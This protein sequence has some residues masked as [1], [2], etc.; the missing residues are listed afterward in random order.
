MY[1]DPV[2]KIVDHEERRAAIARAFQQHAAEHGFAATSYAKVA[3][4][5]GIS[6]GQI[7]HYFGDRHELLE[8]AYDDLVRRRDARVDAC[9]SRGEAAHHSIRRILDDALRELLPLD[10]DRS[11]EHR[12][13]QQLRL[14]AAHDPALAAL[15]QRAHRALHVRV[16]TAVGN[17]TSCG[18]VAAGVDA[19]VAATRILSVAYGLADVLALSPRPRRSRQVHEVLEPVVATVF[20]GRC[21]HH[22]D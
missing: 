14:E 4:A 7:Q 13:G 10:D 9:V 18:E 8:F 15:A 5:A 12:V 19:G 22:E 21:R 2:P 17:G 20:T 11:R 1:C 3:A 6:V 16:R